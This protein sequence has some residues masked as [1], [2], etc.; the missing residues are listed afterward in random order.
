MIDIATQIISALKNKG[1]STEAVLRV[2]RVSSVDREQEG[3]SNVLKASKC[4][5]DMQ[6]FRYMN[7]DAGTTA[8]SINDIGRSLQ[9][10]CGCN[11]SHPCYWSSKPS[12]TNNINENMLFKLKYMVCAVVGF[13]ITPYQAFFHPDYPVYSPVGAS[14][15]FITPS[16]DGRDEEIYFETETFRVN[17]T[18]YI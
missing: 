12:P 9:Q 15:Q 18:V 11:G 6:T 5:T 8:I 13:S 7:F 14:L 4:H 16:S 3:G 17:N 10:R 2:D 1:V